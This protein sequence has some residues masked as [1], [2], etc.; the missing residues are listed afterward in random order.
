MKH[1]LKKILF[2]IRNEFKNLDYMTLVQQL[3]LNL[4]SDDIADL[5]DPNFKFSSN[6]E[7]FDANVDESVY[8]LLDNHNS[9][10]VESESTS[11]ASGILFIYFIFNSH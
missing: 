10:S 9:N 4:N 5:E 11:T 7:D 1:C 6:S 2:D 3:N 8:D